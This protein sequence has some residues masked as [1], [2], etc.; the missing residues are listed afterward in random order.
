V[1]LRLPTRWFI[2][3]H[4]ALMDI[5]ELVEDRPDTFRKKYEA[6]AELARKN[7]EKGILDTDMPEP[8]D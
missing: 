6:L 7:I 2:G 8:N 5:A 4:N 1:N 3:S